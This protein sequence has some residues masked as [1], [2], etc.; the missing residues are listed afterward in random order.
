[1]IHGVLDLGERLSEAALAAELGIGRAKIREALLRLRIEGLVETVP[2]RGSFVFRMTADDVRQLCELR[3]M[4]EIGAMHLA[5]S[6][7]APGLADDLDRIVDRMRRALR[8][9]DAQRYRILDHEFHTRIV[10]HASNTFLRQCYAPLAVRLQVLRNRLALDA[11]IHE[12]SM[13][14]HARIAAT[15][16]AGDTGQACAEM[17][18]HITGTAVC[19]IDALEIE[20]RAASE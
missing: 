6:Q 13:T 11:A 7:G 16:R 15:V 20:S 18:S 9:G 3:A 17:S 4:L 14:R 5:M 12:L 2:G 19:Y 8:R 1:M 10:E